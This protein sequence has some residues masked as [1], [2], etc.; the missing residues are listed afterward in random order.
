MGAT[1]LNT[2]WENDIMANFLYNDTTNSTII[3]SKG[4][5]QDV[6]FYITERLN[7]HVKIREE[8]QIIDGTPTPMLCPYLLNQNLTDVCSGGMPIKESASGIAFAMPIAIDR[9]AQ[10]LLAGAPTGTAPDSWVYIEIFALAQWFLFFSILLVISFAML[11]IEVL[12]GEGPPDGQKPYIYEGFAMTLMFS[13]QQGSHPENRHKTAKRAVALTT[14]MLTFL[15]FTYYSNDITAKMTAGSP[16]IPV[17]TFDDVLEHGYKVIVIGTHQL[18][19]LAESNNGTAKHSV[20]KLFFEEENENI[21]KYRKAIYDDKKTRK[22][23]IEE[24]GQELPE[25]HDWTMENLGSA[26]KQIM[27]D[28]KT[29]FYCAESCDKTKFKTGEVVALKMDDTT[30]TWG[31]FWLRPDSEYLSL[32]NHHLLKAFETG[33]LKRIDN[34]YR[35]EWKPPIK[36]GLTEPE[37]LGITNVMFLFSFL[38]ASII[39]TL[40]LAAIEN[41]VKKKLTRTLN[42]NQVITFTFCLKTQVEGSIDSFI[43]ESHVN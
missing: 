41:L 8:I 17:R 28:Q 40:L 11:L 7:M 13:I 36:I 5:F 21:K 18:R 16:P 9:Q 10:T 29:L 14:S 34:S 26:I 1:F 20:Y 42:E 32:F 6:L 24:G 12:S 3:G 35:S 27:R 39:I 38:G 30:I 22:Q 4:W 23:F 15:V 37:P 31:G 2:L 19:I 43:L 33:I 25:W